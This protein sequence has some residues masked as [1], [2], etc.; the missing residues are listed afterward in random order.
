MKPT[1][2]GQ[3]NPG[4]QGHQQGSRNHHEQTKRHAF[5]SYCKKVCRNE[6]RDYYD[7]MQRLRDKEVNFSEMSVHE[8]GQ[9]SVTDKYFETEQTF[10]VLGFPIVVYGTSITAALKNL[11]ERK[12]D[13]ILLS[14]FLELSDAEIGKM[15]NLIRS[16]V[17][18]QRTS[19]LRELKK[20]FEE[21]L[22]DELSNSTSTDAGTSGQA[23]ANEEK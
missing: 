18:Y 20:F 13:I 9:L 17:Q 12:R 3:S 16:T 15:L 6:I 22:S 23:E 1:N 14:Y 21:E 7:E 19:T 11:P 4:S 10:N 2:H 5:D 8:L